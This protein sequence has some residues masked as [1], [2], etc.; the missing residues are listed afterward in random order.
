MGYP[1]QFC[2]DDSACL[3]SCDLFERIP[4]SRPLERSLMLSLTLTN[5]GQEVQ[6]ALLTLSGDLHR[7]SSQ[8][9][10]GA[11]VMLVLHARIPEYTHSA[12]CRDLVRRGRVSAHRALIDWVA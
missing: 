12:G 9:R 3:A 2:N 5:D 11:L 4:K 6:S 10:V 8:L 1:R 7:L